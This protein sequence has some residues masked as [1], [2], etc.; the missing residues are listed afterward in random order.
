MIR[1]ADPSNAAAPP[2]GRRFCLN[3]RRFPR[4]RQFKHRHGRSRCRG[5]VV[6]TPSRLRDEGPFERKASTPTRRGRGAPHHQ[7]IVI[8]P[9]AGSFVERFDGW[10][11]LDFRNDRRC[12]SVGLTRPGRARLFRLRTARQ[13]HAKLS[14]HLFQVRDAF[15]RQLRQ[16]FRLSAGSA[17]RSVFMRRNDSRRGS[18]RL[19]RRGPAD[20]FRLQLARHRP[21]QRAESRSAV[22]R[23]VVFER[24][25]A[26]RRCSWSRGIA[27]TMTL[28][29]LV[30][31]AGAA[32]TAPAF[33]AHA[34]PPE[35]GT[36]RTGI[37]CRSPRNTRRQ[38]GLS[39]FDGTV[40]LKLIQPMMSSSGGGLSPHTGAHSRALLLVAAARGRPGIAN[41]SALLALQRGE[42]SAERRR[43]LRDPLGR[44]ERPC[45]R[46]RSVCG[47]PCD[48][49]PR[50]S[51]LHHGLFVRPRL[52]HLGSR[53]PSG[54]DALTGS[55]AGS[56]RTGR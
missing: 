37:A 19:A 44:C 31:I 16:K 29:A 50:L 10:R 2:P 24:S 39:V 35:P 55:W 53:L 4:L 20:A 56:L 30:R 25:S 41:P 47:S 9:F 46:L 21:A 49:D 36:G 15:G 18:V 51:A 6:S 13:R 8:H 42:R 12:F 7:V 5:D 48:R 27:A 40:V 17:A 38:A 23:P 3:S 14:K 54:S 52:T 26:Q 34:L 11:A 45:I 43:G 28:E 1:T 22:P 32:M 33:R